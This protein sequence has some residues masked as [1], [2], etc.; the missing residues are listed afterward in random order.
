MTR[1]AGSFR[2]FLR[3]I[4]AERRRVR[5]GAVSPLLYRKSKI[6]IYFV[7]KEIS[8]RIFFTPVQKK[9]SVAEDFFFGEGADYREATSDEGVTPS[10]LF[11]QSPLALSTCSTMS[12]TAPRPPLNCDT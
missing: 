10:E 7:E 6:S 5:T 4:K 2:V 3:V 9:S 8:D 1:S 12:R 11:A